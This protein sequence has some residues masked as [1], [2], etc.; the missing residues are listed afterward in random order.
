MF[1]SKKFVTSLHQIE[2]AVTLPLMVSVGPH[3]KPSMIQNDIAKRKSS[4]K[5]K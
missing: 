1:N 3:G 4:S 2:Y 5:L